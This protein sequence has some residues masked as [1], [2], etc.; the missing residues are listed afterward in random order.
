MVDGP[1]HMLLQDNSAALTYRYPDERLKKEDAHYPK[2]NSVFE[3]L[4]ATLTMLTFFG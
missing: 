2:R 3:D 4:V 1:L